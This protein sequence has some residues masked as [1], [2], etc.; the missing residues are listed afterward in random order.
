MKDNIRIAHGQPTT[1]CWITFHHLE[2]LGYVLANPG[3][4]RNNRW[5]DSFRSAAAAYHRRGYSKPRF[6]QPINPSAPQTKAQ[7]NAIE[8]ITKAKRIGIFCLAVR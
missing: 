3:Q 5:Q 6:I 2:R 4:H 8:A 1:V 7:A